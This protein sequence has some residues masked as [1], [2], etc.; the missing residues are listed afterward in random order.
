MM[1]VRVVL[2]A[3]VVLLATALAFAQTEER[4]PLVWDVARAVLVDPTTYAPA[5]IS[6]ESMRQDWRTSHVL[7]AHGWLEQNP[8]FT[9]SG[10][11]NDVPLVYREGMDRIRGAALTVLRD[12]AVNNLSV[13]IIERLLVARYP[14]RKKL[15]RT[16]SWIERVA[17]ASAVTYIN[18]ADHLRQAAANRRLAREYGYDER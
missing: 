9:I 1:A 12:S 14:R 8:R 16:L 4:R 13:R 6:Y 3:F 2:T 10:R 18:S 17:F 15:I 11:A 7:F 5:P